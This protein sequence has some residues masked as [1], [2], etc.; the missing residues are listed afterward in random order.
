[1]LGQPQTNVLVRY[2]LS[3]TPIKK[4]K[5]IESLV[6]LLQETS[7]FFSLFNLQPTNTRLRHS[8]SDEQ[9]ADFLTKSFFQFILKMLHYKF[10]ITTTKRKSLNSKAMTT[11][12]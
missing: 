3:V 11:R 2:N 8:T 7:N 12:R 5:L 1:M 6:Q 4:I 10:T 9:E